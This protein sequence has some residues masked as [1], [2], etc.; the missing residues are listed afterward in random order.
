VAA[1]GADELD[2]AVELAVEG[3]GNAGIEV[4]RRQMEVVELVEQPEAVFT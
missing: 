4:L 1:D 3:P 2:E